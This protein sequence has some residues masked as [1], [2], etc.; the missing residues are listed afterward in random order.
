MT[1][2]GFENVADERSCAAT[3]GDFSLVPALV[4]IVFVESEIDSRP[5]ET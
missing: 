3:A 5:N 4:I 1:K 2:K